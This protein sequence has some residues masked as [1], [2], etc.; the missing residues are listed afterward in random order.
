MSDPVDYFDHVNFNTRHYPK[1]SHVIETFP[2]KDQPDTIVRICRCWQSRRFPYCDDTHKLLAEMGD[3]VGPFVALM[4]SEKTKR[5]VIKIQ[6]PLGNNNG[7]YAV[8]KSF[9]SSS[10][11]VALAT[12]STFALGYALNRKFGF[13]KNSIS[14]DAKFATT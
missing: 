14:S 5:N 1:Y 7:S 13:T 2:G 10:K 11:V 12:L 4:K 9:V 6:Q 3:D 8:P